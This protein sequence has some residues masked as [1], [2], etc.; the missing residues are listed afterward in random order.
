MVIQEVI[1]YTAIFVT[2]LSMLVTGAVI[3]LSNIYLTG[4][5]TI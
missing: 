3:K 2:L 1:R 4:T 5:V